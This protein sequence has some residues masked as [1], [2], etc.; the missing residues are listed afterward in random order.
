MEFYSL[1]S[2]ELQSAD[3]DLWHGQTT[4]VE[5]DDGSSKSYVIVGTGLYPKPLA[6]NAK[7]AQ[8]AKTKAKFKFI[9]K[10]MA[11]ALMDSRLV[12]IQFSYM[13]MISVIFKLSFQAY[14]LHV[15]SCIS[16]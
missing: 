1:V 4:K 14:R 8:V 10:L 16:A 11:K 12:S 9:G 6:R 5:E 3:L 15:Y 7:P 2:K 13:L